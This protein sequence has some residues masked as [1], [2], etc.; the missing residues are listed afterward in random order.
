MFCLPHVASFSRLPRGGKP[1][2]HVHPYIIRTAIVRRSCRAP[3]PT[4]CPPAMSTSSSPPSSL[5]GFLEQTAS[6]LTSA[7]SYMRLPALASTVRPQ[8]MPAHGTLHH[9]RLPKADASH[10][11]CRASLPPSPPSCTLSKSWFA[12]FCTSSPLRLLSPSHHP[13]HLFFSRRTHGVPCDGRLPPPKVT[14]IPTCT[15]TH[16]HTPATRTR[17]HT[18]LAR[19]WLAANRSSS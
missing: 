7:A 17:T 11:V 9:Q 14:C 4:S 3:R 18:H 19:P 8:I 1:R 6:L 5:T 13:H 15:H 16:T 12:R 2:Q 10:D